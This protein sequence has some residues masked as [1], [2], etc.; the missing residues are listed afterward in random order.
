MDEKW[1]VE[2]DEELNKQLFKESEL[3]PKPNNIDDES[4][5]RIEPSKSLSNKRSQ[6]EEGKMLI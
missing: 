3:E 1:Y 5:L 6:V 2:E 4:D